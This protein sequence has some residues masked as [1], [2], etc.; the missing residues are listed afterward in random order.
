MGSL[1]AMRRGSRDRYFQD[2]FDLDANPESGE[3]LVPEGIEG[4]VAHKGS[5]AGDDSPAR[6]RPAR[7]HGLLRQPRHP[8]APARRQDD[9]RYARPGIAKG[10]CTTSSSPR[11]HRTTG[12]SRARGAIGGVQVRSIAIRRP[13]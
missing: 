8:G 7:R 9:S 10:T 11:K 3:K 1:G 12:S 13:S 4:R 6:R 5:V 2:E